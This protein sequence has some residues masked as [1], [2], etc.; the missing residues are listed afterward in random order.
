MTT[1]FHML[2]SNLPEL[3]LFHGAY[4]FGYLLTQVFYEVNYC[5][6]NGLEIFSSF[7]NYSSQQPLPH[8][9]LTSSL[10]GETPIDTSTSAPPPPFRRHN[11]M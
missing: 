8:H 9:S 11:A 1:L 7:S 3:E 5:S 4:V 10:G 6:L 2:F